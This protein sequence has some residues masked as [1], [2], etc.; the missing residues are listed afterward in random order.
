MRRLRIQTLDRRNVRANAA[1]TGKERMQDVSQLLMFQACVGLIWF[2]EN[3]SE[4]CEQ[5]TDAFISMVMLHQEAC[6]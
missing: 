1:L 5:H 3:V 4:R 6:V 2:L